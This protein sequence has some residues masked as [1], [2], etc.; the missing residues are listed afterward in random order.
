LKTAIDIS[1]SLSSIV[2]IVSLMVNWYRNVRKPLKIKR[3]VVHK[4]NDKATFYLVVKNVKPYS[5]LIKRTDCYRRKIYEVKKKHEENPDYSELLY[6]T[7]RIFVC[8]HEFKIESNGHTDIKIRDINVSDI[9]SRLLFSLDTSHGHHELW[10]KEIKIVDIGK[11]EI[12]NLDYKHE[13]ESKWRAKIVYYW[14]SF[15]YYCKRLL[16]GIREKVPFTKKNFM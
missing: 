9:P 5:V 16:Q 10:C 8:E 1:A 4:K 6:A 3:T 7:D 11:V 12:Y 13:F 2:A 15:M 14:K